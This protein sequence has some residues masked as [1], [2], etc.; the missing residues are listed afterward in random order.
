MAKNGHFV[1]FFLPP[2]NVPK[3]VEMRGNSLKRA[4]LFIFDF[5]TETFCKSTRTH[6]EILRKFIQ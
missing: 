5:S 1:A 2:K 3:W 6:G 4:F